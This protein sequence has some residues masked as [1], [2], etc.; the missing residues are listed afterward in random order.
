MDREC[1]KIFA[2]VGVVVDHVLALAEQGVVVF[3]EDAP[4]VNLAALKQRH[5]D[6]LFVEVAAGEAADQ[7]ARERGQF[8]FV[9]V[10][11]FLVHRHC[12]VGVSPALPVILRFVHGRHGGHAVTRVREMFGA[13]VEIVGVRVVVADVEV[14]QPEVV[15]AAVCPAVLGERNG[16]RVC[17]QFHPQ[18]VARQ[19]FGGFQAG[20][21]VGV[22]GKIKRAVGLQKA[23]GAVFGDIQLLV[24]LAA[25]AEVVAVHV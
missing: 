14:A 15:R 12:A 23:L 16:R 6:A 21:R 19:F 8:V 4:P 5:L 1:V 2:Q 18:T 10:A 20:L 3:G 25:R 11:A 9:K 17:E 24:A 7:H 13:G 22:G